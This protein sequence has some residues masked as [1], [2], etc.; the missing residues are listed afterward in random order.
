MQTYFSKKIKE[1]E[2]NTQKQITGNVQGLR[3]LLKCVNDRI[4]LG[5]DNRKPLKEN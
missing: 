2:K 1:E 5:D 4:N 3:E